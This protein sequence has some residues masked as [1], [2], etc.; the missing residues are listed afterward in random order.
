MR[1]RYQSGGQGRFISID[2][3]AKVVGNANAIKQ[4]TGLDQ[5]TYLSN[6]QGL[7]SYAYGNN[8]PVRVI[9]LSGEYGSDVHY[10][11]TMF[12]AQQSGFSSGIANQ[13]ASWDQWTDENPRTN[14]TAAGNV[15]FGNTVK[16][17]FANR[18][19]TAAQIFDLLNNDSP[20]QA[21]KISQFGT[22]LHTFQDTYSHE[23]LT[24]IKHLQEGH[25]PDKTNL[26][27]QKAMQMSKQSFMMLR[28]LNMDLN[29]SGGLT[30]GKYREQ[31]Q[32]LWKGNDFPF[33]Y[34]V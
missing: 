19:D 16:Y 23:G 10:D 9:D 34:I 5:V 15:V 11:L 31:S 18:L 2:P 12:L 13:I 21:E 17:H 32:Q 28:Q 3:V 1:A 27:P 29:G 25:N 33:L 20:S 30:I 26:N 22:L 8:N 24:R 4:K 6:P 7:N 14:P